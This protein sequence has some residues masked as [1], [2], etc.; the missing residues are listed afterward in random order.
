MW[1]TILI[2]LI[3]QI[4]PELLS[5]NKNFW[6]EQLSNP[7]VDIRINALQ[8]L[9]ELRFPD[10]IEAM[11]R[12]LKDP[13]SE[14]RFHAIRSLA[15]IPLEEARFQLQLRFHEES[16]PYLKS[17]IRR[18]MS[19]IDEVLKKQAEEAAKEAEKKAKEKELED[20]KKNP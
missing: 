10:T 18:S 11:T 19:A 6:M 17:E 4:S 3:I 2:S 14:V 1:T 16:D 12:S 7:S 13:N 9:G 15:K 8:K 5:Q 20:S